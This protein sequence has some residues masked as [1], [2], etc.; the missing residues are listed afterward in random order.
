MTFYAEQLNVS[1]R[2]LGQVTRRVSSR[3]PKSIIDERI[4]TEVA[5]ML[6]ASHC[7]LKEVAQRLGF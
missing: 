6:T 2:Y 1:P 7:P 3:S 5:A 4:V